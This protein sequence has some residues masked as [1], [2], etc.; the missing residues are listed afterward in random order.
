MR[1]AFFNSF[2]ISVAKKQLEKKY[3]GKISRIIITYILASLFCVLYSVVFLKQDLTVKSV[4]LNILNFTAAPY[5]WYVEMYLGLFL[6]IPFLNII[7]NSLPSRKWKICLIVTLIVLT[8]LPSV[9][10]VYNWYLPDWWSLPSSSTYFSKLI[11][12]WWQEIYPLTYYYIG[13][14][15]SE[16]GLKINKFL[17][18]LLILF[19]T[20]LSGTYCFW[21]SY[22][23]N[24]ISGSWCSYQSIF[25]VALTVLVFVFFINI[26][27]DKMPANLARLAQRIS[28]I[29]LG[30]YLVSWVFDKAFYPILSQKVPSVT[31]RVEH[32]IIIV[33]IVSI[34]SLLVA[35]LLS[36]IQFIIE[37]VFSYCYNLY[38]KKSHRSTTAI[39]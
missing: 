3:Y 20:L 13:C 27:Y 1:S 6:L 31:D 34:L 5:S 28:S 4:F 25:V 15:L 22:K 36:K 32:Y 10:N 30:G 12:A 11:P 23:V 8:S 9:V 37:K 26:N 33:P 19:G 39:D 24:F 18:L 16:Y 14:Y 38:C 21:R 7:Y 35:Y 17:N 2:R 29:T